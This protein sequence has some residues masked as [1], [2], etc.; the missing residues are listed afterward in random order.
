MFEETLTAL[1]DHIIQGV[2]L[3]GL[4]RRARPDLAEVLFNP[5]H[6]T[7]LCLQSLRISSKIKCQT[8]EVPPW[9]SPIFST[10]FLNSFFSINILF[11]CKILGEL[12]QELNRSVGRSWD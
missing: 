11:E 9:E 6:H 4:G 10:L 7:R 5:T 12:A 2:I 8:D 1:R 3:A